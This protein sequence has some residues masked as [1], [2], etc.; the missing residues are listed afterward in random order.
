M[1]IWVLFWIC[2]VFLFLFPFI[3]SFFLKEVFVFQA[4]YFLKHVLDLRNYLK[5]KWMGSPIFMV[6]I[7]FSNSL[8]LKFIN[9]NYRW[10][11]EY[12]NIKKS[13][14]HKISMIYVGT[15]NRKLRRHKIICVVNCKSNLLTLKRVYVVL[16]NSHPHLPH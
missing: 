9:L 6:Q 11:Q 4:F 5:G 10:I 16:P 12:E 7:Q 2:K 1:V 13:I 14:I 15:T 8:I 3:A